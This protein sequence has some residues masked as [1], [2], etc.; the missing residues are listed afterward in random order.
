[1]ADGG[2]SV[3]EAADG[4]AERFIMTRQP[5]LDGHLTGLLGA[6]RLT[7]QSRVRKRAWMCRLAVRGDAVRLLCHGK[8]LTFPRSLET[9]LRFILDTEAFVVGFLPG[10][11]TDPD[12]VALV[13]R[14]VEE[15]VLMEG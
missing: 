1:L 9:T 12:R 13:R 6:R 15:G 10:P 14:L 5:R 2:L 3:E 7:A 8:G 11:L 4:L